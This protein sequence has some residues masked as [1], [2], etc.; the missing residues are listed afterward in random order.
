MQE[1]LFSEPPGLE[2][3]PSWKPHQ[4][5]MLTTHSPT[6]LPPTLPFP[7]EPAWFHFLL[8]VSP[9]PPLP[10][11]LV[12]EGGG[13]GRC[14]HPDTLS[15]DT[16]IF[17]ECKL[18]RTGF[19]LLWQPGNNLRLRGKW[20]IVCMCD[21]WTQTEPR[22]FRKML[23]NIPFCPLFCFPTAHLWLRGGMPVDPAQ[24]AGF[25]VCSQS[26]DLGDYWPCSLSHP[27]LTVPP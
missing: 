4:E 15:V 27:W 25:W 23:L 24:Q 6:P 10:F 20:L 13:G 2:R 19:Y 22:S 21:W 26:L 16:W 5:V 17:S 7:C 1:C 9:T 8:R 3:E 14:S 18:G 12:G 11:T